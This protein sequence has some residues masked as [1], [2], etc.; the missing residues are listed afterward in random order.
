[1]SKKPVL[2]QSFFRKPP[3]QEILSRTRE[4]LN[5]YGYP[6]GAAFLALALW[7]GIVTIFQVPRYILPAP[8]AI[9]QEGI[10]GA[11][12]IA[13]HF[14]VTAYE[15]LTGYA[16]AIAFAIPFALAVSYSA[17]LYRSF[18]P[19]TVFLDEV[20]K[21]AVAPLLVTWFGFGLEPKII[22]V[23]IMCIFPIFINGVAGFTSIRPEFIDLGRSA[24]ARE[25]E[26]F[27]KIRLP[28]ALPNLFVGLKMA[29]SGAMVGAVV[30]E[31]LAADRGLGFFLQKS[32]SFMNTGLAFAV[33]AAMWVIGFSL[34]FGVTLLESLAIPWHVSKRGVGNRA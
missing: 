27:W 32:L 10:K 21:I 14:W 9:V 28:N 12:Y 1:M 17:F 2:S 29:G 19:L 8:L 16:V 3:R 25:W 13:P 5:R 33:I 6:V 23:F 4:Q 11:S 22:L 20:P 26:M 31:F 30:A 24:G 34:F 7:Q 15:A 18:Y